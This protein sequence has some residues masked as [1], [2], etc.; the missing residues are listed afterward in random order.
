MEAGG[1]WEDRKEAQQLG[2]INDHSALESPKL[3][4]ALEYRFAKSES[5]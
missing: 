4:V 1:G 3:V 2:I 5:V